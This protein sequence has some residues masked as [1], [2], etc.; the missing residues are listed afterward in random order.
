MCG[1][2]SI[3]NSNFNKKDVEL[4]FQKGSSRGPESSS[5]VYLDNNVIFGF[6]RLAINGYQNPKSE[7]P[8]NYQNCTLICNGEI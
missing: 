3:L 8:L 5:I 1:I 6:H 4:A 2:F 7:Q